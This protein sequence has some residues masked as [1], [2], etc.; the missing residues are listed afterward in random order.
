MSRDKEFV[1][2]WLPYRQRALNY[3]RRLLGDL[4]EEALRVARRMPKF[5]PARK[6]IDGELRP[7]ACQFKLPFH[8]RLGTLPAKK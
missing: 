6:M 4:D 8:F 5:V 1:A 2:Q 3:C 7:V